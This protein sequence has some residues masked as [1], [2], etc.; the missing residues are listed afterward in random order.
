[1]GVCPSAQ[2]RCPPPPKASGGPGSKRRCLT[3]SWVSPV[4]ASWGLVL[5]FPHFALNSPE[6]WA[7][8]VPGCLAGTRVPGCSRGRMKDALL[9][10]GNRAKPSGASVATKAA[11]GSQG[12]CS[13]GV[14]TE[15]PVAVTFPSD[16][17]GG[18]VASQR[19]HAHAYTRAH[20]T[21]VHPHTRA[22]TL[23]PATS[24]G[25]QL[26][27][28]STCPEHTGEAT[29]CRTRV[30]PPP[31]LQQ[32]KS[33]LCFTTGNMTK[34]RRP[35]LGAQPQPQAAL[36]HLDL[37][38]GAGTQLCWQATHQ[39]ESRSPSRDPRRHR[40]ARHRVLQGNRRV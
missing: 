20:T 12:S 25:K 21:Q 27:I 40:A 37:P 28:R 13:R 22:H 19:P 11:R 36:G 9:V 15:Q 3:S 35:V 31:A 33:Q 34:E 1:M 10:V 29:R 18:G 4:R 24:P 32:Q 2:P 6:R 7:A 17:Q 30:T 23:N 26:E 16:N 8:G 38:R 14:R 5:G 39:A